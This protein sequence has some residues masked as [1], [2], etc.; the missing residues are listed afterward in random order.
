M[1]TDNGP[2]SSR[3]SGDGG[4]TSSYV[5]AWLRP[6]HQYT[7]RADQSKVKGVSGSES[8]NTSGDVVENPTPER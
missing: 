4:E 6:F 1:I 8:A 2:E 5:P 7:K 3:N